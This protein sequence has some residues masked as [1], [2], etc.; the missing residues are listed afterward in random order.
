LLR[1]KCAWRRTVWTDS[2]L[3]RKHLKEHFVQ[4]PNFKLS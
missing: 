4:S 2:G 3:L 1:R